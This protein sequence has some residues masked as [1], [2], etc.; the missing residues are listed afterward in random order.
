MS[1]IKYFLLIIIIVVCTFLNIYITLRHSVHPVFE[2]IELNSN[3]HPWE[4]CKD[5]CSDEEV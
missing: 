3:C 5:V 1:D 2:N 4:A